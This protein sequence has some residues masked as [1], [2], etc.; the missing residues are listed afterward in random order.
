MNNVNFASY[1]D[2]NAPYAIGDSVIQ[3]I[4]S[5]KETSEEL[6][7]WFANKQMKANPVVV[8]K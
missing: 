7:C 3:V 6:F 1:A 4:K 5:L 8:F 2:E